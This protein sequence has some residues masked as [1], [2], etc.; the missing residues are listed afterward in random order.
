MGDDFLPSHEAPTAPFQRVVVPEEPRPDRRRPLILLG[1]AAATAA[2]VA[3]VFALFSGDQPRKGAATPT[4]VRAEASPSATA[5]GLSGAPESLPYAGFDGETSKI[6]GTIADKHSLVS[7]P[8][9]GK[10][11]VPKNY[12]PFAVAQRVGEV[13][14]P[15]TLIGSA[16]VPINDLPEPKSE[17]DYR[18]YAERAVGWA[19]RT[20]FPEGSAATWTASQKLAKGK[21]WLLG[22]T[23]TYR[24][25]TSQGLL[26]V[27]EVGKKKPAMV[28]AAV[29]DTRKELWPDLNTLVK[30]VRKS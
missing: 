26:A 11:W 24:G 15:H 17:A 13:A 12:A 25:G 27:V 20:H 22:F 18:R 23:A 10:P 28:L 29:P 1:A 9:L 6:T 14:T 2:A 21:G 4:P 30:G 7:Y 16:M 8:H 5:T 3:G 19:L